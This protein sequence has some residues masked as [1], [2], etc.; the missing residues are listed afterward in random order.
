MVLM[1][2]DWKQGGY[3]PCSTWS[4]YYGD[5]SGVAS[6]VVA[7]NSIRA[8]TLSGFPVCFHVWYSSHSPYRHMPG[9]I[10]LHNTLRAMLATLLYF[11][12]IGGGL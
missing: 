6:A 5:G 4:T 9:Y 7:P 3:V 12:V 2:S 8:R 10:I 11:V 1:I